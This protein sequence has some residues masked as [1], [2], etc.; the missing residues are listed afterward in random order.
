MTSEPPAAQLPMLQLNEH[1]S[2]MEYFISRT[3]P[4]FTTQT[5]QPEKVWDDWQL[6]TMASRR[7]GLR[8]D[9]PDGKHRTYWRGVRALGGFSAGYASLNSDVAESMEAKKSAVSACFRSAGVPTPSGRVFG[10]Q[11]DAAAWDYAQML[12]QNA[13]EV[14]VKPDIRRAGPAV[15]RYIDSR[16]DFQ[17]AWRSAINMV[18][19]RARAEPAVADHGVLVQ[20]QHPGLTVRCYVVDEAVVS[21]VV[22][23]PF[24]AVGDGKQT[25]NRLIDQAREQRRGHALLARYEPKIT[26]EQLMRCGV[27]SSDVLQAQQL[28]ILAAQESLPFGGIPVDVLDYV[29]EPVKNMAINAAWAVPGFTAGEVGVLTHSLH[30]SA[31]DKCS[32][33]LQALGVNSRASLQPHHYPVYGRPRSVAEVLVQRMI[34]RGKG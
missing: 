28:Q 15:S 33:Q 9:R 22:M 24:Y 1:A 13:G 17:A 3:L 31:G 2:A 16:E 10:Q 25:L 19:Y 8:T 21:A 32:D 34:D 27:H 5:F 20:A 7:K 14:V 18:S 29:T 11:D 4:T 6:V 26:E 12:Q 23:V 30:I